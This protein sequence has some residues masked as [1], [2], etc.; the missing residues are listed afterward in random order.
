MLAMYADAVTRMKALGDANP[1]SWIWQWYTHFVDGTTTKTNE[2]NRIFG[3]T[4]SATRTLANETWNT[5]QSHSGQ[6][7]EQFPALAPDCSC[8]T[9]SASSSRSAGAPTSP[10]RIGTTPPAIPPSAESAGPV[11]HADGSAVSAASTVQSARSLA[12]SGLPIQ[13]NQPGDPMDID[14]AMAKTSYSTV[15]HRPGVLPG[16]RLRHPWPH[17]RA[18]RQQQGNGRSALCRARSAVLGAPQQHRPD[19]GQLEHQRRAPI[20][21]TATWASHSF[22]FADVNGVRVKRALSTVF[23]L[24][25]LGYGYDA[26]L[27]APDFRHGLGSD[28]HIHA[29]TTSQKVR[30]VAS[31]RQ[32]RRAACQR[33]V[34]PRSKA[35]RRQRAGPGSRRSGNAVPTWS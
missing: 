23:D 31:G 29:A 2:I 13:K 21:T 22:V 24:S 32:T 6:D 3:T 17:P 26:Y 9:S 20:P 14:D 12:N 30:E 8:C 35:R 10:C 18:R 28:T 19:V 33:D 4:P 15:G 25:T 5:C 7:C 27:P 1:M 16:D 34:D 11:P